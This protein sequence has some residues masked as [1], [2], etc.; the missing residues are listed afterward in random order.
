MNEGNFGEVPKTIKT[1]FD[2]S[3]KVP[4][5]VQKFTD[6]PIEAGTFYFHSGHTL[7]LQEN[8]PKVFAGDTTTVYKVTGESGEKY[9][10]SD[11]IEEHV[12]ATIIDMKKL[13]EQ[14]FLIYRS[15]DINPFLNAIFQQLNTDRT[16]VSVSKNWI[17]MLSSRREDPNINQAENEKFINEMR[18]KLEPAKKVMLNNAKSAQILIDKLESF[19]FQYDDCKKLIKQVKDILE[20]EKK[21]F[22]EE[23]ATET[24]P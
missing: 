12:N 7:D 6:I 24:T 10:E 3:I 8:A 4:I 18:N 16:V 22:D 23:G 5:E 2:A 19:K 20:L 21:E 13:T 15:S 17:E 11:H 1:E 14:P 9:G